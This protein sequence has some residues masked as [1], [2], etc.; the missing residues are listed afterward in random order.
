MAELDAGNA[1]D[2]IGP[3]GADVDAAGVFDI[4][5]DFAAVRFIDSSAVGALV[6]LKNFIDSR[7]GRLAL[8]HVQ[9]RP[10]RVLTITGLLDAF[11]AR[12][13]HEH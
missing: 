10:C 6:E 5:L 3:L 13:D 11:N 12:C 7:D 4:E 9:P 2:T 1:A 8:I